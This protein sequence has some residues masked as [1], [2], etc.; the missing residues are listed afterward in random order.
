MREL[1]LATNNA[2]KVLEYQSLLKGVRFEIVTPARRGL[3]LEVRETGQTY[4]ENSRLKAAA[5]A[6]VSGLLTLADDSGLEVDALNGEPGIRSS[7]Y[8]GEGATD[9]E[10]VNYLLVKLQDVPPEKRTARFRC[11]IA[12]A[13]PDGRVVFC[14]GRCEG[15]ITLAPKGSQGFGYDPIFY[16]PELKK[17]MAELPAEIKNSISHR[18]RAAREAC[19]ILNNLE[20][21][22]DS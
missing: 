7:R 19:R 16:F 17:T 18:A 1:L 15:V 22:P 10:R 12:I 11:V 5:F 13:W 6:R 2:G 3:K 9:A 14:S 4:E 21:A 8:A 20:P